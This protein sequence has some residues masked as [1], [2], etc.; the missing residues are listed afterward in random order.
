MFA[1]IEIGGKQY[2]VK[3]N[4]VIKT[5][6]VDA[7]SA[8]VLLTSDGKTTKIGMPF[9]DGATVE[10]IVKETALDKKVRT[11]KMKAKKRYKRLKGHRQT[12]NKVEVGKISV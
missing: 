11:F 2:S 4:D 10:L 6:K 5:E 3:T 8:R 9:V 12:F 7:G 1:I